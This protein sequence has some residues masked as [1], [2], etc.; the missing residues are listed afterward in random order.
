MK[1][2][3]VN[4]LGEDVID[5]MFYFTLIAEYIKKKKYELFKG[6]ATANDPSSSNSESESDI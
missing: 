1:I 3:T 2:E 6:K 5:E 4:L